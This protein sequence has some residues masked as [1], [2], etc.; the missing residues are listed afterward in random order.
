MR[1]LARAG[2]TETRWHQAVRTKYFNSAGKVEQEK[3]IAERSSKRD[4]EAVFKDFVR[5]Y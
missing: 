5:D 3:V 2:T 4:L 1:F